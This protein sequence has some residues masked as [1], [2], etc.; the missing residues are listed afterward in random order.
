MNWYWILDDA[1]EPVPVD[2]VQTWAYWFESTKGTDERVVARTDV[3]GGVV[4]STVFLGLDHGFGSGRPL[5]YESMVFGGPLDG[6]MHRYATRAD[7][8]AG[9]SAILH[10]L[11]LCRQKERTD[12]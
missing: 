3:G 2:D 12:T 8:L 7:A 11:L 1:G 10:S 5:L 6:E 9:H 4:L